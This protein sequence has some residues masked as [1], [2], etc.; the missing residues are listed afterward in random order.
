[1]NTKKL[2]G[3]PVA[4]A[5]IQ[6][7]QQNIAVLKA[8]TGEVP[9][10]MNVMVGDSEASFT[11]SQRLIKRCQEIQIQAE[12]LSLPVQTTTPYL[13]ETLYRLNQQRE[14]HAILLQ[15]PFP[16]HIREQDVFEAIDP[17]K[18]V[19]GVS[20][21]NFGRMALG[22]RCHSASTPLG[23]VHLLKY[24]QIP[25]EGKEIIVLGRSAI[26]GKPMA[27]LLLEENATVTICHSK[28][29]SLAKI[30]ARA[31]IL[32][33][34][35]GKA[36]FVQGNWLKEGAVVVDA[37]YTDGKGDVFFEEADSKISAITPVPG[38]VGPVTIATLISQMVS[39]LA[40]QRDITLLSRV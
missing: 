20:P 2:L 40:W 13:L 31:D 12:T 27:L 10:L 22:S 16:K 24:Y 32:V 39:A 38:G 8:K 11:Y 5:L 17:R 6:E 30:I 28:T 33:S 9:R 35:I 23:I 3:K 37:G 1:M 19:D 7:A 21:T 29:Q 15:H 4:D 14:L 26:L 34:A 25:L 36:H 18:D